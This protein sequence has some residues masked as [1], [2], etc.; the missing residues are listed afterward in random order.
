MSTYR[1]SK[2]RREKIQNQYLWAIAQRQHLET[3]LEHWQEVIATRKQYGFSDPALE[4]LA[5]TRA[6][7]LAHYSKMVHEYAAM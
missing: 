7:A 1:D 3:E 6:I 5:K 4:V 2:K